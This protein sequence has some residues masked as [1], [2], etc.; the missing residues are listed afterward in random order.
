MKTREG[1]RAVDRLITKK[2]HTCF[3]PH[4]PLSFHT[5]MDFQLFIDCIILIICANHN[6]KLK[7]Q[8]NKSR[9][10]NLHL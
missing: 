7:M 3:K 6:C 8:K 10:T 2:E 5:V 9:S 1:G 4:T